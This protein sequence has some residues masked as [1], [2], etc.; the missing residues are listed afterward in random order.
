M[1]FYFYRA[2]LQSYSLPN[3]ISAELGWVDTSYQT[4]HRNTDLYEV[5]LARLSLYEM[6]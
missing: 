5:G 4:Q 3:S 6:G 2:G 1:A